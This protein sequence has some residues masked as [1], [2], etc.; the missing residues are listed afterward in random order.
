M[1]DFIEKTVI[2]ADKIDSFGYKDICD[3]Q[4]I[5][6]SKIIDSSIKSRQLKSFDKDEFLRY[7]IGKIK[8]SS[9]E[10]VSK[11]NRV[12]NF[13]MDH[14]VE[15]KK[16]S[17]IIKKNIK[18]FDIDIEKKLIVIDFCNLKKPP[19]VAKNLAFIFHP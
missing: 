14:F 11:D 10:E 7:L 18:F 1:P 12:V 8:T 3:W 19:F 9:I 5:T 6:P 2:E 17:E 4:K 13:A 16:M 15:E